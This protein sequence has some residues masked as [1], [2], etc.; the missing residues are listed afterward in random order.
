MSEMHELKTL[1]LAGE[2]FDSF[3]DQDARQR[4]PTIT[5]TDVH[6]ATHGDGVQISVQQGLSGQVATVWN[7]RNGTSA[8]ASVKEENG[9]VTITT[10]DASGTNEVTFPVPDSSQNANK[11]LTFTG[12]VSATYDGSEEVT[13]NIPV[14]G[15]GGG[16]SSTEKNAILTILDGVIVETSKQEAITQAL[17]ALK[18][19]WSGGEVYISQSGTTLAFENVTA[20][21]T[22][23]QTGTVLA[24][25]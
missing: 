10:K 1:T 15:S 16:L 19:L 22:I 7:G 24:L 9:V 13:V 3:P 8:T 20:V 2:T 25:A 17:A 6:D 14:G 5:L 4:I 11:A 12:A 23:T 18:Q 21:T